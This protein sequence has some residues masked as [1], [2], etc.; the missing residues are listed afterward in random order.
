[1][2]RVGIISTAILSMLLG[3][4]ALAYAQQEQQGEKQSRLLLT[5]AL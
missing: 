5:Q 4:F 2:K 3:T 1:M